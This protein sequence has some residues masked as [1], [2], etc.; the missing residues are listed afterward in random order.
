MPVVF[1]GRHRVTRVKTDPAVE[2]YNPAANDYALDKD[3]R[4][5]WGWGPP[6]CDHR[7]GHSCFRE[8][9]HPGRC[10]DS[11]EY[12]PLPCEKSQRPK[13]WDAVGRA[14]ANQ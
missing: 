9:G 10:D 14:E 3:P 4:C 7:F 6:A 11:N 2:F 12:D 13:H 8:L 5:L 1:Q